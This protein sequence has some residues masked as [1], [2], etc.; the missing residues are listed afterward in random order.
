MTSK[1]EF[2]EVVRVRSKPAGF[3]HLQGM[4]GPVLGKA[5]CDNGRWTYSVSLAELGENFSLREDELESTGKFVKR[6]DIYD[7]SSVRVIVDPK[8]GGGEL[9]E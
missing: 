8:S 1:F 2:F 6:E 9:A 7:G 4:E 5:E 3:E